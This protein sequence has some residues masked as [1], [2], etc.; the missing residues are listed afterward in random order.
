MNK[1]TRYILVAVV[2]LSAGATIF[3]EA[4]LNVFHAV[5]GR[6]D[7]SHGIFVPFFSLY[8]LW[9]KKDE[10]IRQDAKFEFTGLI[11]MGF[12]LLIALFTKSMAF[13]GSYFL[14]VLFILAAIFTFNGKAV[15]L[16][17]IFPIF[18]LLTATPIPDEAYLAIANASRTIALAASLKIITLFGIPHFREEW[19]VHLPTGLLLVDVSCSGIRYLIS[20]IVFGMAYAYLFK[21]TKAQ[22]I[23][24]VLCS[25][26][27]SIIASIFRLT[28]I[29]TLSYYIDPRL[30][31]H[32]PHIIISWIVFFGIMLAAVAFDL[33]FSN[34]EVKHPQKIKAMAR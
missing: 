34:S 20:Y 29:F 21:S 15:L 27:I 25:L 19:L 8:F 13:Q 6:E 10:L 16:T 4:L 9:L 5:V 2:V 22:R 17:W 31:D 24:I 7:S 26:P 11:P 30:A 3:R 14:F 28:S 33:R 23:T 32:T 1:Q 12:I 18:F